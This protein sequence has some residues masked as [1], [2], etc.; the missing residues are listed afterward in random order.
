MIPNRIREWLKP[1]DEHTRR[2]FREYAAIFVAMIGA[3]IAGIGAALEWWWLY[4]IGFPLAAAA[5]LAGAFFV[6][7]GMVS[8]PGEMRQNLKAFGERN[9]GTWK[10]PDRK[11]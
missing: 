9:Q 6:L 3:A 1:G 5:V 11:P 4:L 2:F 8:A 7:R 10:R